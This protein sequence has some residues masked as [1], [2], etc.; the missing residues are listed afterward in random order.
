MVIIPVPS[1]YCKLSYD[2]LTF[3]PLIVIVPSDN[4]QPVGF[5]L[6]TLVITGCPTVTT[7]LAVSLVVQGDKLVTT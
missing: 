3:N 7:K 1:L 5:V 4:P 6:T 2:V